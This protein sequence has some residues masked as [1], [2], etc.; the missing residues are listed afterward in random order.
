MTQIRYYRY[1]DYFSLQFSA[2][3]Q[4]GV[5][6]LRQLSD[7][8][9]ILPR[10]QG[11]PHICFLLYNTI[12]VLAKIDTKTETSVDLTT[13]D[14]L[15]LQEWAKERFLGCVIPAF[16]LPLAAGARFTQPRDHSLADPCSSSCRTGHWT[17]VGETA[18]SQLYSF[19]A[20]PSFLLFLP[21]FGRLFLPPSS[22][23]KYPRRGSYFWRW[24]SLLEVDRILEFRNCE[25]RFS[26][27][28]SS[29]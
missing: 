8:V 16:W 27:L 4:R 11:S 26:Y 21:F 14:A 10:S 19:R 28:S 22:A 5:I 9:T 24:L 7:I 2:W 29:K 17:L 23:N 1:Y 12:S 3:T 13:R 18:E 20:I 15:Y 25:L 6:T